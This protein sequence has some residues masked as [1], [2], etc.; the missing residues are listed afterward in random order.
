MDITIR[1]TFSGVDDPIAEIALRN[2]IRE[3]ALNDVLESAISTA[4]DI[5]VENGDMALE[6]AC[7]ENAVVL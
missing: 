7:L 4:I 2:L 1:F 6:D 3:V 5:A